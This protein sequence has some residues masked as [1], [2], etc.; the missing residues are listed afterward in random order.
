MPPSIRD[1]ALHTGFSTATVS[2]ALR[3]KGR[4]AP[5]TRE[6]IRAAATELHYQALPNLSRAL[7]LARH[8]QQGR[9]RETLAFI[10]EYPE[11]R[12]PRFQ[13]ELQ[14]AATRRGESLGLKV[15]AFIVSGSP[16]DHRRISRVL[17]ARGIRGVIICTRIKHRQSR[18]VLD[19][20]KFAAVEIGRS[21][22]S[23]DNLHKVERSVFYEL[24]DAMHLLKKAGYRRIG[25]A[26]EPWEEVMRRGIYSAAFLMGQQRFLPAQRIPPLSA[27]AAWSIQ[28]F[29]EWM[30]KH[31]PEVLIVYEPKIILHWLHELGLKV[32]EDI[33]VFSTNVGESSFSGLRS[34]IDS[35]GASC[36]EM[37][38]L[39]LERDELGLTPHFRNW[40]VKDFWQSGETLRHPIAF[41]P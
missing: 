5:A 39:L 20:P 21:V 37:L 9:F 19:W 31:R 11:R 3:D 25:L 7:S 16:A 10:T 27:E 12:A 28:T 23:P 29:R 34:D 17:V 38:S 40:L 18:L 1:I 8:P 15:E 41:A 36:V 13:S 4:M 6:K 2:L 32:P 26:I 35:L 24:A 33:S 14:A 30:F 22:W